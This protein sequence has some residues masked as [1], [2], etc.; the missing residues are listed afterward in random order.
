[1]EKYTT[2]KTRGFRNKILIIIIILFPRRGRKQSNTQVLCTARAALITRE[3][4]GFQALMQH[5]KS[6]THKLRY[7]EKLGAKQLHLYSVL[8]NTHIENNEQKE[9]AFPFNVSCL[10]L[11][12]CNCYK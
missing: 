9:Q 1:M 6:N 7:E 8:P 12:S 11:G 3:L 10:F 4:K 2:Y 5:S